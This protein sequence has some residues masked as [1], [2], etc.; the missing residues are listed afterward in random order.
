MA[1][2][3]ELAPLLT[4]IEL[5]ID[6]FKSD[7][8]KAGA[9]GKSEAE[10]ISKQMST[11]TK[12]GETLTRTGAMLTKNVTVPIVGIGIASAKM[13]ID[14]E[15]D[16]AKVST[17]L[18]DTTDFSAYK[19]SIIAGSNEMKTVVG[20]YS[21]AVYQSISAGVDQAN[22]VQFT[23][24][25]IKLAKGGFTSASNAVDILTTAI[26]AYGLEASDATKVSDML[27]TTQNLGK[28]F[29]STVW[30]QAA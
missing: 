3:I 10:K 1:G 25:A 22:A 7:M 17:L 27:V 21:D 23:N 12:V 24:E 29:C 9:I 4:K 13:A 26:N 20:D 15:N 18:S 5:D 6:S 14:F 8:S 28:Q 11:L 30:K 19:G 16:F 2:G